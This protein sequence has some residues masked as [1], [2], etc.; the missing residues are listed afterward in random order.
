MDPADV[1]HA[2]REPIERAGRSVEPGA[3]AAAGV[4]VA[5]RRIGQLVHE[6]V[7]LRL[8]RAQVI[9][10]TGYGLVDFTVTC[11]REH[12]R[13]HGASLVSEARRPGVDPRAGAGG[14]PRPDG[15]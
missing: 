14:G 11:L 15:P 6:P 8:I 2:I 4:A 12:R 1:E 13:E 5:R 7:P 10:E 9:R 3:L